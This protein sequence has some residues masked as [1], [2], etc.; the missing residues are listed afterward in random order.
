MKIYKK[1]A[2]LASTGLNIKSEMES[3]YLRIYK[4]IN[5]NFYSLYIHLTVE[6]IFDV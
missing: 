6:L 5:N 4:K 3:I 2:F 1:I